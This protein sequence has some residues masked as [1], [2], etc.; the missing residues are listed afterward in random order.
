MVRQRKFG[1]YT[2][3]LAKGW[4]FVNQCNDYDHLPE[5]VV[6]KLM[7]Q[8]LGRRLAERRG[9]RG[10]RETAREIGIT[11]STLL[12]IEDGCLPDL[13]TFK[14]VCDWLEVDPGEVLGAKHTSDES[15]KVSVHFRKHQTLKP[16]T[17]QA[18]AD[19]ILTAHRAMM[20]MEKDDPK[21]D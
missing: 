8:K 5:A 15:P 17:A 3:S 16:E 10:A 11:H 21:K 20:V 6:A 7:M 19:L 1:L 12:R 13:E 4:S 14:K 9:A 18:L 2:T